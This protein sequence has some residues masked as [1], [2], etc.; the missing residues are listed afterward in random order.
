[1]FIEKKKRSNPWLDKRTDVLKKTIRSRKEGCYVYIWLTKDL[2]TI[3]IDA[4]SRD[5]EGDRDEMHWAHD[6][7]M[8]PKEAKMRQLAFWLNM[9]LLEL[10]VEMTSVKKK[11]IAILKERKKHGEEKER[12]NQRVKD[13]VQRPRHIDEL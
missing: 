9:S 12:V 5:E 4:G 7:S 10:V 8:D 6:E 11:M 2:K 1:M 13:L 3:V